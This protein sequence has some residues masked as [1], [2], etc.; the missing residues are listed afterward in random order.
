VAPLRWQLARAAWLD[1]RKDGP[2]LLGGFEQ[3]DAVHGA[4]VALRGHWALTDVLPPAGEVDA[5]P[6]SAMARR[7]ERRTPE[8]LWEQA[9][10]IDPLLVDVACEGYPKELPVPSQAPPLPSDAARRALCEHVRKLPARGS[11]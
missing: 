4:W 9:V 2:A 10:A 11:E 1:G 5:P 8:E 7:L 3:I 6:G